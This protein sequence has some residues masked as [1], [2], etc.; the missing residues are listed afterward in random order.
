MF[1]KDDELR[2][3]IIDAATPENFGNISYDL[4]I[5]NILVN[6]QHLSEYEIK[7]METVFVSTIETLNVPNDT[8]CKVI[9]RNSAIRLGLEIV[10][11]IYQP[12]HKTRVFFRVTNLSNA[13]V[14]LKENSSVCS[15]MIYKLNGASAKPYGG[16]YKDE[17]DFRG[18]GKFH[19][20][21]IPEM[22]SVEKKIKELESM[23]HR[24]YGN[25]MLMLTVFVAIFS[26]VNLNTMTLHDKFTIN[27]ILAFNF[28]FICAI[29]TLVLL[30]AEI[31]GNLNGRRK[32]YFVP[33]VALA[34]AMIF[35]CMKTC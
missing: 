25:V 30:V 11:P 6:N 22:G 27:E 3:N 29:S 35:W 5:K 17:F 34:M 12:G 33:I 28:V 18:V 7:P 8:F 14:K 32:L 20:V 16:E 15:L 1:L 19:T 2:Q 21:E 13:S 24:L 23:E 31:M 4:R 9:A 26:L 10:A